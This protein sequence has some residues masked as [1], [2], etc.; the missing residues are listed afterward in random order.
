MNF[1]TVPFK[2]VPPSILR[3]DAAPIRPLV[4]VVDN[5]V[6][7]ANSI[8]EIL[9][10][11]GFAAVPTY[12][13]LSAIETASVMPPDLLIVDV[14][15]PGLEGVELAS[16]V[17]TVAPDCE[18][19]LISGTESKAELLARTAKHLKLRLEASDSAAAGVV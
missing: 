18:I 19:L 7:K 17:K 2:E 8:A 5:K 15:L 1:K 11:N 12:D 10:E 14:G 4:L 16:T 3:P 6:E 9:T 13:P